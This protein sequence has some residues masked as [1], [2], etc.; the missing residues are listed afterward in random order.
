MLLYPHYS[1]ALTTIYKPSGEAQLL[2]PITERWSVLIRYCITTTAIHK[3]TNVAARHSIISC[4]LSTY[5]IIH[6][7]QATQPHMVHRC[8]TISPQ[9]ISHSIMNFP[10]IHIY[11]YMFGID[12]QM[13]QSWNGN[14]RPLIFLFFFSCFSF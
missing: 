6:R 10:F 3:I 12:T 7:Q 13:D 5:K 9:N 4:I 8:F 11:I 14:P 1:H 2:W